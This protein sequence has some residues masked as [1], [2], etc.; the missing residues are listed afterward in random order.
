MTRVRTLDWSMVGVLTNKSGKQVVCD[1]CSIP[2]RLSRWKN[3]KVFYSKT[4]ATSSG[5]LCAK[6]VLIPT[7]E[8][9][10]KVTIDDLDNYIKKS[11]SRIIKRSAI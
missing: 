2:L 1:R 8:G 10:T 3:V 5:F 4:R 11:I 6:C 9:K 7:K